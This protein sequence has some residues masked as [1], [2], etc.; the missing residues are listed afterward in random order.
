[1]I[2]TKNKRMTR[3]YFTFGTLPT[4]IKGLWSCYTVPGIIVT[5]G[6][7]IYEAAPSPDINLSS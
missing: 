6:I 5:W 7:C 1:M 4:H 3:L 2:G